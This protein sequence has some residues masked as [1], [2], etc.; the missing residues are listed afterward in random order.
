VNSTP[1]LCTMRGFATVKAVTSGD[2]LVLHGDVTNTKP[3][4]MQLTLSSLMAP[5]MA[6]GPSAKDEPFGYESREFLR[7]LAVGRRVEF[8]VEYKVERIN[9]NFGAVILNGENLCKTVVRAGWARVKP[10]HLSK[11]G[12]SSDYDE[13][14]RLEEEAKQAGRGIHTRVS[15]AAEASV[16]NP[17]FDVEDAEELLEELQGVPQ[18]AVVEHVRDGSSMRLY[19]PDRQQFINFNVSGVQAPRLARRAPT[20]RGVGEA[21]EEDAAAATTEGGEH[22]EE[23]KGGEP[24][25]AG[26]GAG[27]GVA[28]EGAADPYAEEAKFFT[29]SRLLHRMVVAHVEGLNKTG[30]F[31]GSIEHP[32]GNIAE[33]LLR[34]GLARLQGWSASFTS[35]ERQLELR[36]A[37]EAARSRGARL[38]TGYKAPQVAGRAEMQG[39]IGEVISGDCV[40]VLDGP[41]DAAPGTRVA[42]RLFLSSIRAPRGPNVR[43]GSEGDP[44]WWHAKE[45]L[46]TLL[47]GRRVGVS[48]DYKRTPPTAAGSTGGEGEAG[49]AGGGG[50]DAGPA[51]EARVFGTVTLLEGKRKGLNAAEELVSR[52]LAEVIRHRLDEARSPH[53]EA[54]LT[55]EQQARKAGRGMHGS[56]DGTF[57]CADVSGDATKARGFLSFLRQK[58]SLRAVVVF[59]FAGA[60]FKVYVPSENCMLTFALVGIRCPNPA[61]PARGKRPAQAAEPF[62]TEALALS[63]ETV[64]QRDVTIEVDTMDQHGTVLGALHVG[65]GAKQRNLACELLRQGLARVVGF[66]AEKHKH[67]TALMDAEASAREARL[68]VWADYDARLA[69]EAKAESDEA[70]TVSVRVCEIMSGS[71]F[72]VHVAGAAQLPRVEEAM[73]AFSRRVGSQAALGPD[74]GPVVRARR[75]MVVAAL[76]DAGDGLQ[77]YR[78]R[79]VSV[80]KV[81]SSAAPSAAAAAEV[82]VV[83]IDY[84]TEATLR[85]QELRPLEQE[86]VAVP[87]QARECVTA[88]VRV[89]EPSDDLGAAAA[90]LFHSLVWD[91]DLVADIHARDAQNRLQVTLR[92]SSAGSDAATV[93]EQ[94]LRSGLARVSRSAIRSRSAAAYKEALLAAQDEAHRRRRGM[95]RYGAPDDTD[96]E[97]A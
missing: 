70:E 87:A 63:R 23:R 29:E 45:A 96:N 58:Q 5:R 12:S 14:V 3:P 86:L 92:D 78:A 11:D 94:L 20:T 7:K 30:T 52:G 95:F 53:Y 42:R 93:T 77:W 57:R 62:G 25:A 69:E 83:C 10:E 68:R 82:R 38:W 15:G 59:V 40:L 1:V 46:R 61:R 90:E 84:G 49:A 51:P 76:L 31:Y 81:S 97:D 9:R 2:S 85:A 16:R 35:P 88:F 22:G 71:R 80:E 73:R 47:I 18:R 19:L 36:K 37:Q 44:H 67:R 74:G 43:S 60:R 34:A 75:D 66:S 8:V 39:T 41:A 54:L 6:R 26:A 13:L 50:A 27:A 65:G 24:S 4:E 33:E 48:I 56:G 21:S 17:K 55:A 91:R 32:A 64:L 72:F 28:G 79:V 89:P